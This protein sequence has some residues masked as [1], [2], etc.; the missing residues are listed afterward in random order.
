MRGG[1]SHPRL[2]R[3]ETLKILS[4]SPSSTCSRLCGQGYV[5]CSTR[6]PV[7]GVETSERSGL[8]STGSNST[9]DQ[10]RFVVSHNTLAHGLR[11]PNKA[12]WMGS[13]QAE[14][15]PLRNQ[16][17][18]VLIPKPDGSL[19]FCVDYRRLNAMTVRDTYPITRME[20]CLDSLGEANVFITLACNSGYW[21]I[22]VADEDRPKTTFTCHAGTYQFI[23]MPFWLMK[24]PA[25]FRRMLDILLSGHR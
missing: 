3:W 2:R 20:E 15:S 18:L 7:C 21:Q 12:L 13:Y 8:H 14:S 4:Q 1:R 19:R 6:T 9:P 25:T 5:T 24:A 22:P 10:S 11:K 16:N 17:G 23:R